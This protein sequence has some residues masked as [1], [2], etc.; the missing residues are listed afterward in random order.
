MTIVTNNI[1]LGC[2]DGMG[3]GTGSG[4]VP[5]GITTVG[6]GNPDEKVTAQTGSDIIYD[7]ANGEFYIED[8]VGI[9]GSEWRALA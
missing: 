4:L 3:N 9:G 8:G 1:T 5:A 2:I 7:A 6:Q